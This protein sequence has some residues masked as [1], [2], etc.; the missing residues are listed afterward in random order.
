MNSKLALHMDGAVSTEVYTESIT[1]GATGV[2]QAPYHISNTIPLSM[3]GGQEMY[4]S[5]AW[6]KGVDETRAAFA[7]GEGKTFPNAKEAIRWLLSDEE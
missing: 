3:P 6:L 2:T 1:F 4:W 7:R 5:Y